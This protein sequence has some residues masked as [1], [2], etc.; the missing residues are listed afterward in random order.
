MTNDLLADLRRPRTIEEPEWRVLCAL[1]NYQ[2]V[3]S[4]LKA[5]LCMPTRGEEGQK[6]PPE[7]AVGQVK[8]CPLGILLK[9]FKK[10]S[11]DTELLRLLDVIADDRNLMAH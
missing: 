8:D 5:L 4:I 11:R 10:I 7:F 1:K 3:E 6:I 9:R 2:L